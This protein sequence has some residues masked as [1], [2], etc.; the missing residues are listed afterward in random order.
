MGQLWPRLAVL[1]LVLT[2]TSGSCA[3]VCCLIVHLSLAVFS[4]AAATDQVRR[5]P[6]SDGWDDRVRVYT[7][8]IRMRLAARA[9]AATHFE[10]RTLYSTDPAPNALQGAAC[11]QIGG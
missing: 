3:T 9:P 6:A 8:I 10:V 5:K 1:S 7:R 4:I 11:P 2:A